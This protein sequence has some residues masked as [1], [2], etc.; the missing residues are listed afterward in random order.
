[1]I[2]DFLFQLS[3]RDQASQG[4]VFV[5]RRVDTIANA[6]VVTA[7]IFSVPPDQCFRLLAAS[8]IS[9]PDGA[10]LPWYSR[11]YIYDAADA[12]RTVTILDEQY[13]SP[14]AGQ[15]RTASHA[16]SDL[17]IPPNWNIAA[18]TVFDGAGLL[19]Q[20]QGLLLGFLMPRGNLSLP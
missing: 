11:V 3:P 18:Q 14:V 4:L 2:G 17:I 7:E 9:V 5:H 10:R 13:S 19:N 1:M 6:A 16:S 12:T 20:T 8:C 15:Y